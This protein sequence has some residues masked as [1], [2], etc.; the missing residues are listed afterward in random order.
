MIICV[1][2]RWVD[3]PLWKNLPIK[4]SKGDPKEN[5]EKFIPYLKKVVMKNLK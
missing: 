3:T 5:W 2:Q 4:I 1:V